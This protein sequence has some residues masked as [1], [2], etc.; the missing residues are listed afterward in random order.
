M[1]TTQ[2]SS[3]L[4]ALLEAA[5][6]TDCLPWQE[7]IELRLKIL[8]DL[9]ALLSTIEQAA[10][11]RGL[12]AR[13]R[14]TSADF[15]SANETWYRSSH[16]EIACLGAASSVCRWLEEVARRERVLPGLGFDWL[17]EVVFGVLQMEEP[18]ERLSLRSREMTDYQP[19]PARHI[20][21]AMAKCRLSPDDIFVDLGAGLG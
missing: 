1:S 18:V 7:Q 10:V 2:Y 16:A 11:D 14:A 17:G 8:D 9:D 19:T 6:K 12:L 13:I 5:E 20:F 3:R 21:D 15:Q 4:R